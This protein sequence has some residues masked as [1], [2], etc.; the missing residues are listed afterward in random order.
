[1]RTYPKIR[2]IDKDIVKENALDLYED[3]GGYGILAPD[4]SKES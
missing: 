3:W 2:K 1:V 4:F